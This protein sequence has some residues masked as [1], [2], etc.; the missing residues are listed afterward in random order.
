[1]ARIA[2]RQ[3]ASTA[4]PRVHWEWSAHPV[5]AARRSWITELLEMAGAEN[6]YADLDVESIRVAPKEAIARQPDVFVAC[7][8][9]IRRLPSPE[10][11]LTRSGWQ[12]T[13]AFR[14]RRVAVLSE[15]FF[16][17]P[18]P[19]LAEGLEQLATLLQG[20]TQQTSAAPTP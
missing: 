20:D 4:R 5:V 3:R 17:R 9:G 12:D 1:M 14:N 8:C 2:D 18:G 19:R 11:I 15:A 7:W 13:P 10:R 6:A 16:G